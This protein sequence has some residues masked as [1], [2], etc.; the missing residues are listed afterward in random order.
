MPD[1]VL[2][3]AC[4][5]AEAS[6]Y[7]LRDKYLNYKCPAETLNHFI[8]NG[9]LPTNTLVM[10][11]RFDGLGEN[12]QRAEILDNNT[13]GPEMFKILLEIVKSLYNDPD[14]V[15]YALCLMN[16]ILEDMRTRVKHI[17]TLIKSQNETRKTDAIGILYK[18]LQSTS[19]DATPDT[20]DRCEVAAHTLSIIIS[21]MQGN[22][23]QFEA[24]DNARKF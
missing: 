4:I 19:A 20:K 17:V 18:F 9:T 11:N 15:M 12:E 8:N 13:K 21:A 14:L 5:F 7:A 6:K 16:G 10:L 24:A 3:Y 23:W 1:R 22:D 2:S